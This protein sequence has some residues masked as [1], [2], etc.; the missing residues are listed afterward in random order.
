[1]MSKY[2]LLKNHKN[3]PDG[4]LPWYPTR[5]TCRHGIQGAHLMVIHTPE[6]L[7]DFN[8]PDLTAERVAQYGAST[9]RASWHWST[10]SDSIIPMLP[11]DY[12]AWHVRGYNRC[13]IGIELGAYHDTWPDAP[14][15]WVEQVIRNAAKAIGPAMNFYK[16]PNERITS[17]EA[18][19]GKRGL[20]S[21]A[22]LDPTRRKDPG[23]TFPWD[24][25]HANLEGDMA[26]FTDHEIEVL[27]DLVASLD[28]VGSNGFFAGPAVELIRKE[29]N[30]PLH[31]PESSGDIPA[32]KHSV[33]LS[34]ETVTGTPI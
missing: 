15:W 22:A 4:K 25:L 26:A 6:S 9:T 8:P 12:T 1:M 2:Y 27:K 13:A 29:R 5:R 20:I 23:R 3:L 32:H 10:D 16:I 31:K 7:E 34:A 17:A 18:D 24:R 11:I 21:H 33:K 19:Q 14:A 28:A 30:L